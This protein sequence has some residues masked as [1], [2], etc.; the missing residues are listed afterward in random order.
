MH[1]Q[2]IAPTKI[3]CVCQQCGAEYFRSPAHT[4]P[5]CSRHCHNVARTK[6][7]DRFWQLVDKSAGDD[8]CWTWQGNTEDNGYGL[9]RWNRR[10]HGAHR[11]A[12]MLTHGAMPVGLNVCHS[13]DNPPCVNPAHLF[14]GTH[15]D[16]MADKTAKE[17]MARGESHGC[18]KLTEDDVRAIRSRYQFRKVTYKQLAAEYGVVPYTILEIVQ[19]KSWT[20]IL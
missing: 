17:R 20:H 2:Y 7:L 15:T 6:P 16:N 1:P 19:R 12:Y 4:G 5:Y 8:A 18:A 13:C 3:H 11:I 9:F 14:L 10:N